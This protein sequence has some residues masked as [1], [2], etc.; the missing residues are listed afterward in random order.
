[1]SAEEW[2]PIS[3]LNNKYE[4][5]SFGRI[6]NAKTGKVLKQFTDLHGYLILT[7]RPE[8]YSQTNTRVHQAVADAFLGPRPKGF[9]VNHI[10]GNKLNNTPS[11]LEYVTPSENNIHALKTGLRNRAWTH[12]KERKC[13]YVA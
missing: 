11:N 9:V 8:P 5:S 3:Y 10:D 12:K 2:K 7:T 13:N 1:M 6:R 4:A